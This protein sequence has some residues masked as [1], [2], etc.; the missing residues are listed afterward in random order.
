MTEDEIMAL[1][2]YPYELAERSEF[3]A[4]ARA[5]EA[6]AQA[7]VDRWDTPLWKDA[8]HP[9]EVINRLRRVLEGER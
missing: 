7:V 8:E 2:G 1:V 5:I 3:V 6:A 4:F 9:A